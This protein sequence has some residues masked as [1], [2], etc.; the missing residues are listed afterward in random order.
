MEAISQPCH[1]RE[2]LPPPSV[3]IIP[4]SVVPNVELL[5]PPSMEVISQVTEWE[6]DNILGFS[7]IP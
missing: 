6:T 7:H 1:S 3:E 5:S 2:D 4:P